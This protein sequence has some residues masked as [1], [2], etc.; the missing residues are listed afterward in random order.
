VELATEASSKAVS[1][2]I[3]DTG[4]GIP[5]GVLR[6]LAEPFMPTD[7]GLVPGTGTG[8]ALSRGLAMAMG[9]EL[10]FD[11]ETGEGTTVTLRL[12]V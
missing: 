5:E 8:L 10:L 3:R 2:I 1:V 6:R 12:P 4:N 7:R 9:A 11:S